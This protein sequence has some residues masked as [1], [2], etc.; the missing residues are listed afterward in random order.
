M[1]ILEREQQIANSLDYATVYVR[2]AERA[3]EELFAE[4]LNMRGLPVTVGMPPVQGH[5]DAKVITEPCFFDELP[6]D[7]HKRCLLVGESDTLADCPTQHLARPLTERSVE[8]AI[9]R[10]LRTR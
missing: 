10:F 5:R 9:D 8:C 2:F 4:L 6:N 7:L 3:I 1:K